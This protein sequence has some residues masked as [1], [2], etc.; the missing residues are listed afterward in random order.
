M[1]SGG[2]RATSGPPPDPTALRRNRKSDAAGWQT[3]PAEGR[4]GPPPDWPLIDVQPREWDLW[5]NLWTRPQAVMWEHLGLHLEVALLVR[6]L[7]EAERPEPRSDPAKLVRQ[8]MDSLGLTTPGLLRNRWRIGP[9]PVEQAPADEE[10]PKKTVRR[11]SA[12]DRLKV[13]V[14]GTGS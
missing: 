1:P 11:K 10:Q 13:V 4:L 5:R 6:T 9:V 8:Y 7:A 12:R 14:D 3:L 2:A